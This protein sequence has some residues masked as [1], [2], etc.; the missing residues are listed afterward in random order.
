[1]HRYEVGQP[2]HP[3]RRAWPEGA[4]YNYR[5]GQHE[6]VLFF[7]SP[8]AREIEAVR[9][10]QAEFGLYAHDDLL[11]LLYRFG[12]GV[13]WSDAPYSWHLLDPQERILPGPTG[14]VEP[15]DLMH[16]ILVD[17][18]SGTIRALRAVTFSPA[19]TTVIRSAIRAQA[20]RPFD[21]ARYDQALRQLYQRYPTTETLLAA[22]NA[23]T[24][25]GA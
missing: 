18:Q 23:R 11:V 2:Y 6:L 16:I 7:R 20:T 10:G 8:T 13:P 9:H 24:R 25:G 12:A 5:Q 22:A 1:M 14:L 21:A 3:S 19:F 17:A 4:Q 15:H